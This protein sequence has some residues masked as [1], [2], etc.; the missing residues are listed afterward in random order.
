[1]LD[2]EGGRITLT[3]SSR[4]LAGVQAASFELAPAFVSLFRAGDVPQVVR[5]ESGGIAVSISRADQLL[6]AVGAVTALPLESLRVENGPLLSMPEPE[7]VDL[8]SGTTDRRVLG[9]SAYREPTALDRLSIRRPERI[10]Q[11]LE[12]WERSSPWLDV[13]VGDDTRRLQDGQAAEVGP[14]GVWVERSSRPGWPRED[15]SVALYRFDADIRDAAV[16]SARLLAQ[17]NHS[18]KLVGW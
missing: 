13:Q 16:E 18:L 1:M 17:G 5:N 6:A 7:S 9:L 3:A 14:Y 2:F 12:E 8:S 11:A 4:H 10:R 15:E